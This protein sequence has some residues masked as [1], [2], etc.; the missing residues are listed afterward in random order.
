MDDDQLAEAAV[1]TWFDWLVT[2]RGKGGD[3][4]GLAELYYNVRAALRVAREQES[5]RV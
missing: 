5:A 3:I 2:V 1:E 4:N